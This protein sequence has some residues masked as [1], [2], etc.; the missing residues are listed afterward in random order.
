MTICKKCGREI[1]FV[2]TAAGKSM[3]V[4]PA[5]IYCR[6]NENGKITALTMSGR[7]IRADAAEP[8]ELKNVQLAYIPH[9]TSCEGAAAIKRER[10]RETQRAAEARKAE[11]AAREPEQLSLLGC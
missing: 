11:T 6:A 1:A 2:K 4:E 8:G 10:A 5:S 7:L 3:P 9:W